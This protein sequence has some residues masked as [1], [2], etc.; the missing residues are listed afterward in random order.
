MIG[1]VKLGTE[2][3]VTDCSNNHKGTVR[4]NETLSSLEFCNGD[5]W[6]SPST[7]PDYE[8]GNKV[9]LSSFKINSNSNIVHARVSPGGSAKGVDINLLEVQLPRKGK[10]R[11][12]AV[13]IGLEDN[14]STTSYSTG[15]MVDGTKIGTERTVIVNQ[16]KDFPPVVNGDHVGETTYIGRVS[17]TENITLATAGSTIQLYVRRSSNPPDRYIFVE[18]FSITVDNPSFYPFYK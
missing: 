13:V 12:H 11:V 8:V 17:F 2:V 15:L 7:P 14:N 6:V 5:A 9:E 1:G 18:N 16:G 10:I 4:Y 3:S